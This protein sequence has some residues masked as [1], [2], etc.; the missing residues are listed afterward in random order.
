MTD[1]DSI[2]LTC[3]KTEDSTWSLPL[4]KLLDLKAKNVNIIMLTESELFSYKSTTE[5]TGTVYLEG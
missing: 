2:P 4:P 3:N 5:L 1:F